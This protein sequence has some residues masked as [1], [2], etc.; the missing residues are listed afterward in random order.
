MALVKNPYL[1]ERSKYIDVAYHYIRDLVEKRR[2]E[3]TY[4]NTTDIIAD[5]MTKP[6]RSTL[7]G[8]FKGQ[9]GVVAA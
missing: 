9:L 6:L 8:R 4:V 2:L 7:F 1:Y 3:V 5:S